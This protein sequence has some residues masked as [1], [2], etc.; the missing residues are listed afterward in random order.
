MNQ[1]DGGLALLAAKLIAVGGTA[2]AGL[3]T[4]VHLSAIVAKAATVVPLCGGAAWLDCDSVLN[5]A[6]SSWLSFPVAPV[7]LL[8]W[9]VVLG[10]L[11]WPGLRA[12]VVRQTVLLA[13]ILL[14]VIAAVFYVYIQLVELRAI[15]TW[16]MADHAMAI[17]L[18]MV[19]LLGL[20]VELGKA[21]W[22]PGVGAAI[23]S[24]ALLVLGVGVGGPPD[25]FT[26]SISTEN[27]RWIETD[28]PAHAIT[29]SDGDV[30][31][32]RRSHPVIGGSEAR[33]LILE[34]V[35]PKCG[36][37][38]MFAPKLK[39][40]M[41]ML[42]PEYGLVIGYVPSEVGCNH[43]LQASPAY[44]KNSCELT[45]LA[46]A[47]WLARPEAFEPFHDWLLTEQDALTLDQARSRA[48]GLVGADALAEA[49]ADP[50]LSQMIRRDVDLAVH[51]D[52]EIL[53]GIAVGKTTFRALPTEP[54]DFA[55]LTRQLLSE[56][57]YRPSAS[58]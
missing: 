20:R 18:A 23:V 51:M 5:S 16:C 47:V 22:G 43:Y 28:D 50:R 3:L 37:C 58:E 24:G 15:C 27:G 36:R 52:I 54:E 17:L 39:Q 46:L 34:L 19:A 49:M 12:S 38:A 11:M 33:K 1:R 44:G 31:L 25:T 40:A 14:L 10:C 45:K 35:D 29:F 48:A 26:V 53:P 56:P 41:A 57:N 42:G 4:W 9:L 13:S 55:T 21:R 7:G 8:I 32:D 6:W 30:V 2:I